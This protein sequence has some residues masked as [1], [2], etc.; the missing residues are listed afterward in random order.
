MKHRLAA[1]LV[2]IHLFTA[3]SPVFAGF[4]EGLAA[5]TKQDYAGA[6]GEWRPLAAGGEARAQLALGFMY[7]TGR[8]LGQDFKE[9]FRWYHLAAKQ[10]NAEAQNTLGVRYENGKGVAQDFK[11]ALRWYQLAANQGDVIAQY[12]VGAMYDKGR[13]VP[14]DYKEAARWY[15]LA[16]D[17]GYVEAQYNLGTQLEIGQGVQQ[18][19]KEAVRWYRLAAEQGDARAQNNLGSMFGKAQGVPQ[20][21]VV[22]HALYNLA[23]AQGDEMSAKN[24]K[25]IEPGM[26][27]Q[28]IADAQALARDMAQPGKLLKVLDAYVKAHPV[29]KPR[30]TS[31]APAASPYPA[32]PA[33]RPGVVSCNTNCTNG[34]CYR[35]Y[36]SGRKVHFQAKHRY[37]ALQ[38]NWIWDAGSC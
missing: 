17:Q 35:T 13:G 10:G 18:D 31:S 15:R 11:E 34:D 9:A 16:A 1:C 19:F 33:K 29:G 26:T 36:D 8:G 21:P 4:E 7:E 32:Q 23:R 3:A 2:A 20:L 25:I 6:L 28:E 30:K 14:Q 27:R 5:F 38:G 22:Q 24:L 12:N 37:D